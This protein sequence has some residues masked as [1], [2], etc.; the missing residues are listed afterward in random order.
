MNGRTA[1][2]F[3]REIR[4]VYWKGLARKPRFWPWFLWEW[5]MRRAYFA[6]FGAKHVR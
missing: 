6:F 3:R 2:K 5:L 1:K 4:R